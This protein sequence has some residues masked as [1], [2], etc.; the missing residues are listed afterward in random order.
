MLTVC[1]QQTCM[2]YTI[3]VCTVKNS[4]LKHV[5]FHSKNKFEKS[6]HLFGF[7]IRNYH[8]AWSPECQ[9]SIL[10]LGLPLQ[11]TFF[12]HTSIPTYNMLITLDY[13]LVCIYTGCCTHNRQIPARLLG[14]QEQQFSLQLASDSHVSDIGSDYFLRHTATL[15]YLEILSHKSS[16]LYS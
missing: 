12:F 9:T 7:I 11:C 1:K 4:C 16:Q 13:N 15:D 3:A 6:V 10:G 5:E 8:N 14:C 2:T